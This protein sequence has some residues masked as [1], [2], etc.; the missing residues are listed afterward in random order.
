MSPIQHIWLERQTAPV[1]RSVS[2]RPG[3]T[4]LVTSGYAGDHDEAYTVTDWPKSIEI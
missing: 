2:A 1:H 3:R 4:A